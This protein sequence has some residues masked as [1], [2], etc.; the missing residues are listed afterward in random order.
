MAGLGVTVTVPIYPAVSVN[1]LLILPEST[2]Y[3]PSLAGVR[4]STVV[5][6]IAAVVIG[7]VIVP[8]ASLNMSCVLA[9]APLADEKGLWTVTIC[10]AMVQLPAEVSP[11]DGSC[12][13]LSELTGVTNTAASCNIA[14]QIVTVQSPF[15]SANGAAANT[16]LIFKLAAGTITNPITTAAITATT[17]ETR[18]PASDGQYL[19]DS[20]SISNPFTLTA[21]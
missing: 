10:P 9:A 3:C 7:F 14:G 4:V 2:K 8:A 13:P 15:S 12:S 11:V 18:T 19:V 1:G 17:V 5:A 21:G 16:Q 6:V 20:G